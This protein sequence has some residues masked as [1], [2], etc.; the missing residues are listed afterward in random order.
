MLRSSWQN[1]RTVDCVETMT[2][3]AD[4]RF[5]SP[6]N[7]IILM[8]AGNSIMIELYNFTVLNQINIV[9]VL[10]YDLKDDFS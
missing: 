10:H 5:A 1:V 6:F 4:G 3:F 2:H 9:A 7:E 8:H